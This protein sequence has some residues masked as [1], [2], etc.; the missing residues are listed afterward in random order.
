V[1]LVR[2]RD[3]LDGGAVE[4]RARDDR[5]AEIAHRVQLAAAVGARLRGLDVRADG[6]AVVAAPAGPLEALL[7]DELVHTPLVQGLDDVGRAEHAEAAAQRV[8]Y[9]LIDRVVLVLLLSLGDRLRGAL[10]D[11]VAPRPVGGLPVARPRQASDD[12]LAQA[13]RQLALEGG[14]GLGGA[15]EH[16]EAVRVLV[17]E[18]GYLRARGAQVLLHVAL[19]AAVVLVLPLVLAPGMAGADREGVAITARDEAAQVRLDGEV[20]ER[21]VVDVR[22]AWLGATT[23]AG[24]KSSFSRASCVRC[25]WRRWWIVRERAL[26]ED[27]PPQAEASFANSASP[28]LSDSYSCASRPDT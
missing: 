21:H 17:V 6:E 9:D 22:P 4:E 24:A 1:E 19:V 18:R 26:E 15:D 10:H 11:A 23:I 8:P 13:L 12:A 16:D 14:D 20:A 2:V 27:R 28:F 5:L 7:D 25:G 3:H